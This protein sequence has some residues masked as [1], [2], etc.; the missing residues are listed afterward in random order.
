[1]FCFKYIQ[2]INP[3]IEKMVKIQYRIKFLSV[4]LLSWKIDYDAGICF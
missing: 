2:D 4:F 3:I 1:M